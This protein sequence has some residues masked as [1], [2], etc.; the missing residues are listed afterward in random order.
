MLNF[1]YGHDAEI[2]EFV[3]QFSGR[4]NVGFGRCK[5][6]GVIDGEGKLIARMVA[7]NYDETS[8]VIEFGRAAID[9]RWLNRTTYRRM[10]EYPFIE[11][12]CQ[13]LYT[14]VRADNEY[15]LSQ[16]ARLNFELD[17]DPA[18]VRARRRWRD[19]NAHRR[20]MARQQPCAG[21]SKGSSM[22]FLFDTPDPPN[23]IATDGSEYGTN[24]STA[25]AN[26][27]LGSVNQV[28]PGG[29]L[30]YDVT[31]NYDWTDPTS[32][33]AFSVP[34]FTATQ[35]LNPILQEAQTNQ[36]STKKNLAQFGDLRSLQLA[37]Q[38]GSPIDL[39]NAPA[40]G[41]PNNLA[42]AP[43]AQN[44]FGDAGD[45][46]FG[47]GAA[48]DVQ[49]SFGAA[50]GVQ[51][52]F[53]EAGDITRS[54]EDFA[55]ETNTIEG[56]AVVR[57]NQWLSA[58]GARR[59]LKNTFWLI[60]IRNDGTAQVLQNAISNYSRRRVARWVELGVIAVRLVVSN[61]ACRTSPRNK[62]A[63]KTLRSSKR[64]CKPPVAVN[65]N[66]A[67]QQ[68]YEQARGRGQFANEAEFNFLD[69]SSVA[70]SLLIRRNNKHLDKKPRAARLPIQLLRR[71]LRSS[72]KRSTHRTHRDNSI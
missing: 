12:G 54:Y 44:Q 37:D 28:T 39:N 2:G 15:L 34:K 67:E 65:S 70:V 31:G 19:R 42:N 55:G 35:S 63:F 24:V 69:N 46:Q 57:F 38:F 5:T 51:Q 33:L 29:S 9:R 71:T 23:P 1:V 26:A 14:R 56:V 48:G 47:F 21:G 68:I 41:N 60:G 40:F 8:G 53:G 3:N 11:C 66:K 49:Q 72:S 59:L 6:I 27:N 18:H 20:S 32:G 61:S 36:D 25:I 62:L 7:C 58:K 13:L 22:S 43:Q 4:G 10:F 50:P 30:N 64:I 17:T 52:T 45:P 16:M